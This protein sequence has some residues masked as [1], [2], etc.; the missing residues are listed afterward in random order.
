[1]S[2]SKEIQR[3]EELLR[4]IQ[5]SEESQLFNK[6]SANQDP[7]TSEA[8]HFGHAVAPQRSS[9]VTADQW[10]NEYNQVSRHSS[11]PNR[12]NEGVHIYNVPSPAITEHPEDDHND[13]DMA[14]AARNLLQELE[15]DAD[16]KLS[17]SNFVA[18]LKS[19]A[20]TSVSSHTIEVSKEDITS[21]EWDEWNSVGRDWHSPSTNGYGYA[22]FAETVTT[23]HFHDS[24]STSNLDSILSRMIEL[25]RE[26]LL[27]SQSNHDAWWELGKLNSMYGDDTNALVAFSNAMKYHRS[28]LLD[29]ASSCIN[30]SFTRDAIDAIKRWHFGEGS[31]DC[32][33][34]E[35][36]HLIQKEGEQGGDLAIGLL[37]LIQDN[38]E[39]ALHMFESLPSFDAAH[40]I[41]AA[42]NMN[43][44]GAMHANLGNYDRALECYGKAIDTSQHQECYLKAFENTAISCFCLGKVQDAEAWIERVN[45]RGATERM[46]PSKVQLRSETSS[47]A[48]RT[49]DHNGMFNKYGIRCQLNI[50]AHPI[51]Q[52][53][54]SA[55]DSAAQIDIMLC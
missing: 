52:V 35:L 36:I 26:L 37:Y 49:N 50:L 19:L 53:D 44:M 8:F 48:I 43:R 17:S 30:L 55:I 41:D 16:E 23:Y 21:N 12:S 7:S 1:M 47:A 42:E 45:G 29:Y 54:D 33:V 2:T 34:A 14:L 40:S 24:A 11:Y 51:A 46:H 13:E 38:F 10:I 32:T 15:R 18:Y 28:A 4:L 25:E 27:D 39:A 20:G 6:R 31:S 5:L 3:Q 9:N 22:G